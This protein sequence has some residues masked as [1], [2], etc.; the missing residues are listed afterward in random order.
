ME[1]NKYYIYA[2][3][4]DRYPGEYIY[5]EYKFDYQPFYIGKGTGN[6][7]NRSMYD[8]RTFKSSKIKTIKDNGGSVIKI[9]LHDNL[10]FDESILLEIYLIKLIGRRDMNLGTLVNLTDGG[11]GRRNSTPTEETKRK[12]SE[13]I[14]SQNRHD[15]HTE[16][17]IE[18]LR[19]LNT[20]VSNPMYGKTHSV[21]FKEKQSI[22]M[23]GEKHPM[24]GKKH[25]EE[26]RILIKENRAK[27]VNQEEL[28]EL[29]RKRNNKIVMQYDLDMNFMQEFESVKIASLHTGMSPSN[30]AKICRDEIKK[31]NKFIF[32]FKD[33]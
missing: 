29:S 6:R 17:T 19:I 3:L 4:D 16:E 13:T 11:D 18:K 15:K 24:Y 8:K 9:K 26:T 25:D 27:A 28:N 7:I 33:E 20:G 1:E 2:F 23:A 14:K 30:I 10:F 21:E 5:E 31:F 22:R 32:K 12:I